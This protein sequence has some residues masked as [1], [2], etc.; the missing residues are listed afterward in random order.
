[1]GALHWGSPLRPIS[2][3]LVAQASCSA[4][5][6]SSL[7]C[8]SGCLVVLPWAVRLGQCLCIVCDFS[9]TPSIPTPPPQHERA[10]A[11]AAVQRQVHRACPAQARTG[12]PTSSVNA[13][14]A[15]PLPW[16]VV[17]SAPTANGDGGGDGAWPTSDR[18]GPRVVIVVRELLIR[19]FFFFKHTQHNCVASL[20]LSGAL[21]GP[22]QG[23]LLGSYGSYD[24]YGC[25]RCVQRAEPRTPAPCGF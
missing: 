15:A 24:A 2:A 4:S 1:V 9:L 19:N 16:G 5:E 12:T 10:S 20:L 6:P 17:A 25:F 11:V 21:R 8:A 18:R 22:N 3:P 14:G 23:R 7:G 13:A